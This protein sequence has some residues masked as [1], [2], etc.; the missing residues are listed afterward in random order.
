MT[1]LSGLKKM[2]YMKF[3]DEISVKS[4]NKKKNDFQSFHGLVIL[5]SMDPDC[6]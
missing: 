1:F 2:I 6:S 5:G 3:Q 4:K